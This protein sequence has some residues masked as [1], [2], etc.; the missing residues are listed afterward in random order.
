MILKPNCNR[1]S[2]KYLYSSNKDASSHKSLISNPCSIEDSH[3]DTLQREV[4]SNSYRDHNINMINS[5]NNPFQSPSRNVRKDVYDFDEGDEFVFGSLAIK[6]STPQRLAV[7]TWTEDQRECLEAAK[8]I[9]KSNVY[10]SIIIRTYHPKRKQQ[11]SSG[12][13]E[14]DPATVDSETS[15][16]V[17]KRK[18]SWTE[19]DE[20]WF[21][22]KID[23]LLQ[24]R[25]IS[26]NQMK[27]I[28]ET[29]DAKT[30]LFGFLESARLCL[31]RSENSLL[32]YMRAIFEVTGYE[33]RS[34]QDIALETADSSI[35][36]FDRRDAEYIHGCVLSFC[37]NEGITLDEFGYRICNPNIRYTGQQSLY[38]EILL[39]IQKDIDKKSLINYIKFVYC[40]KNEQESWSEETSQ[41]LYQL[42]S[43]QGTKWNWI[44]IQLGLPSEECALLWKFAAK[45]SNSSSAK[46]LTS[47]SKSGSTSSF[48][49]STREGSEFDFKIRSSTDKESLVKTQKAEDHPKPSAG[50]TN[51][52]PSVTKSKSD[53]KNKQG[54]KKSNKKKKKKNASRFYAG[55][56]LQLL[57][58]VHTSVPA[59]AKITADLDWN[60]ISNVMSKW[61]NEELKLQTD[62]LISTVK[63][64]KKK[65]LHQNIK[66][67]IDELKTLPQGTLKQ[68][69]RKN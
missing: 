14:V 31:Q 54:K 18:S 53:D 66:A 69:N 7:T 52:E 19:E 17:K 30:R 15:F 29:S 58:H 45:P 51:E 67:A 43:E 42:V 32:A 47:S 68:T 22:C 62:N 37:E 40:P 10:S 44:A 3:S 57:E 36:V 21:R 26:P 65:P 6:P 4:T 60:R 41:R 28:L 55:D 35:P 23:E 64:W 38:N 13:V 33:R 5:I 1:T 25:S 49:E 61:T 24:A 20:T 50:D 48:G 27:E 46:S 12:D 59:D 63:G 56:S 9:I 8:Q 2:E 34:I 39:E 16:V 11:E